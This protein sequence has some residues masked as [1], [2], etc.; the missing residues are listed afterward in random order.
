MEAEQVKR[1][2]GAGMLAGGLGNLLSRI[3][4]LAREIVLAHYWGTGTAF[5]A[6]VLAFTVP[7]LFR[8]IFGEGALSEV[9]VPMFNNRLEREGKASA[10]AVL[11]NVLSFTGALL[12][13]LVGLGLGLALLARP[14]LPTGLAGLWIDLLPWLLPYA[15]FVCTGSFLAGVLQSF[16]RFALAALAPVLLNLFLIL[17]TLWLCPHLGSSEEQQV[18][19]LAWAVMAAG[20]LQL[21]MLL[22]TLRRLGYR[23]RLDL[24][25][26]TPALR[27]LGLLIL[28]GLFSAGIYQ[29]GVVVDRV[30]AGWLGDYAVASLY[31]SQRLVDLPVGIFAVSMATAALPAMSRAA[32]AG[33]LG[34]LNAALNYGLRQMLFITAPCVVLLCLLA[35]PVVQLLFERGKFDAQSTAYTTGALYYLAPA[36]AAYA[37]AKVVRQGFFC[38][39]DMKTPMQVA[40]L[41]VGLNVVLNLI[42]MWPLRQCGI[43]LATTVAA[44]ANAAILGLLLYRQ[45]QPGRAWLAELGG[46]AWRV[47]AALLALAAAVCLV[48][49]LTWGGGDGGLGGRLLAVA[50][51]AAAGLAAYLTASLLLGCREP[52]ELLGVFA[53]RLKRAGV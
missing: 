8:R 27:E 49:T 38:R 26:R 32:A 35:R 17:A 39:Q 18:R 9:F 21:L 48:L 42:L 14:W 25:L 13:G 2:I 40:A 45:L 11:S 1:S 51:P 22:P 24:R 52:R 30:T 28:P 7:N 3:L 15:F 4:G 5:S 12:L 19:G 34:E 20:I 23:F 16:E 29:L 36:I 44:F 53:R 6:F 10:F 46:A 37:L 31:Y 50:L 43:A 47:G 33:K 41:C